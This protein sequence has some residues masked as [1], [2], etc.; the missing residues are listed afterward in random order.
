M[1]AGEKE[2]L[3]INKCV[4]TILSGILLCLGAVYCACNESMNNIAKVL[5]MILDM[6]VGI[7]IIIT[8]GIVLL[9]SFF[10]NK[11]KQQFD[12]SYTR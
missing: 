10:R 8:A 4:I 5:F 1:A 9:S 12:T 7:I 11:E 3:Y 6:G 2:S